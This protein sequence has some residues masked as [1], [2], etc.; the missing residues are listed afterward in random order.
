MK[1]GKIVKLPDY[2]EFIDSLTEK[3]FEYIADCMNSV[4]DDNI[5]NTLGSKLAVYNMEFL[6]LYHHW[7]SEQLDKD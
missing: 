4:R 6:R 3:D 7:L 5:A 2:S 1:G